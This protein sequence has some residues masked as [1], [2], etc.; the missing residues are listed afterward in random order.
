MRTILF[1]LTTAAIIGAGS[2]AAIAQDIN[3]PG[4]RLEARHGYMLMLA[5][6]IATLGGMAKGDVAYDPAVAKAAAVNLQSLAGVDSS[7][8]WVAGT[9]ADS[10]EDSAALPAIFADPA[11]RAT[12]FAALKAAAD[13]MAGAAGTDLASLQGAMEGLGGACADCHKTFRKPE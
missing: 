5:M 7:F 9:D 2:G 1:G 11:A 6:N 13:K 10:I 8:L 3:D 4:E 12:K